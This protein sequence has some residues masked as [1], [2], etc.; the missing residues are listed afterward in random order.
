[1]APQLKAPSGA[2][3][4]K[5]KQPGKYRVIAIPIPMPKEYP[6]CGLIG[7]VCWTSSWNGACLEIM[8]K[9]FVVPFH[10]IEAVEETPIED[11][12]LV[13]VMLDNPYGVYKIL[14]GLWRMTKNTTIRNFMERGELPKDGFDLV[15][16]NNKAPSDYNK[17]WEEAEE[18]AMTGAFQGEVVS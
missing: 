2:D 1:M 9:K 14:R 15:E 18:A 11:A 3:Y 7:E 12:E 17:Q 10:C 13:A 5:V 4:L 16:R 6:S 8:G